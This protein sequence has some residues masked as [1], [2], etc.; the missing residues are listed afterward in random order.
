MFVLND[1]K[2][3]VFLQ[4]H[5]YVQQRIDTAQ[6]A[7]DSIESASEAETKSSAGDKFETSREMMKQEMERNQRLLFDA[8]KMLHILNNLS[9]ENGQSNRVDTGTLVQTDQG[10]FYIAISAG[11]L[12]VGEKEIFALSPSSPVGRLLMNKQEGDFISFNSR[13]YVIQEVV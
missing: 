5:S 7:I 3:E 6:M 2:K 1:I 8:Q 12:T 10:L 4:C 11:K 13:Q 9:T